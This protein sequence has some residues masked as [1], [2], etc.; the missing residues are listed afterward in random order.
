MGI[1]KY[2]KSA[3]AQIEQEKQ[4]EVLIIREKVLRDKVAPYNQ[5]IEKARLEAETKL[6]N[7]LN[8]KINALREQFSR[9]KQAIMDACAKKK[10]DFLNLE[11]STATYDIVA[12]YD[13]A[14]AGLTAQLDG[15]NKE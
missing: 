9:D 8:E 14:I 10:E 15:L 4:K 5:E 1:E 12:Q 3:I 2:I 6:A 13:K 7:E 11:L